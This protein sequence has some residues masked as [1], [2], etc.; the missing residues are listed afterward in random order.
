MNSFA[1]SLQGVLDAPQEAPLPNSDNPEE[2]WEAIRFI[3]DSIERN[4][5]QHIDP[6]LA[7]LQRID[8]VRAHAYV[9]A[10]LFNLHT[11]DPIIGSDEGTV[12]ACL[13]SEHA[14]FLHAAPE[15]VDYEI[16]DLLDYWSQ[17]GL[18]EYKED[19]HNSPSS[20]QGLQ[21]AT[22]AQEQEDEET[23]WKELQA[24][25]GELACQG[26]DPQQS[27]SRQSIRNKRT[28]ILQNM[29][30]PSPDFAQKVIDEIPYQALSL[31]GNPG[32]SETEAAPI[33]E[34]NRDRV[35]R[36]LLEDE[37]PA[38][39]D[40]NTHPLEQAG[41]REAIDWIAQSITSPLTED[42]YEEW[43]PTVEA[44][45]P[46]QISWASF[47]GIYRGQRTLDAPVLE[48]AL[49]RP[50]VDQAL[51]TV[52]ETY[53]S[54]DGEPAFLKRFW[55]KV[56][57]EYSMDAQRLNQFWRQLRE[58]ELG[59]PPTSSAG[60]DFRQD[61]M[62]DVAN[63]PSGNS[64]LWGDM[65]DTNEELPTTS[66]LLLSQIIHRGAGQTPEVFE[67]IRKHP[68]FFKLDPK[69]WINLIVNG[70]DGE[71]ISV[72]FNRLLSRDD[73]DAHDLC[74]SVMSVETLK[75]FDADD[76]QTIM[77]HSQA[78]EARRKAL[79]ALSRQDRSPSEESS[80]PA[81]P[82]PKTR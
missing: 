17:H 53:R 37:L 81:P 67:K 65:L 45:E 49:G 73:F 57:S 80:E 34:K 6:L 22:W 20:P 26:A 59:E 15:K 8:H 35:I 71:Q 79:R 72:L 41:P 78:P 30:P 44:E 54:P 52:A 76:L 1:P 56:L 3:L 43:E 61:I 60:H 32:L 24:P 69:A 47:R 39:V 66:D 64:S 50:I 13:E 4:P 2:V 11:H 75:K 48:E 12:M 42:D 19:R 10:T 21:P 18:N 38:A 23:I 7:Y 62:H 31:L 51:D 16:E 9:A 77:A 29:A 63:H 55:D 27:W 36:R 70:E 28:Q 40:E 46:S 58:W 33:I 5:E 14:D 82:S 74:L 68:H 25:T